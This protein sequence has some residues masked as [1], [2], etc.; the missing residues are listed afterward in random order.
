[1]FSTKTLSGEGVGLFSY[2]AG[3]RSIFFTGDSLSS[4]AEPLL[5]WITIYFSW[6]TLVV[7]AYALI[8]IDYFAC[9][10]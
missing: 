10:T 9:F 2:M 3:G 5:K 8:F 6:N 7:K 4:V 1:M